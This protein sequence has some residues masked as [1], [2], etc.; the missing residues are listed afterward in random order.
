VDNLAAGGLNVT[1]P[2][3]QQA[4]RAGALQRVNNTMVGFRV[5]DVVGNAKQE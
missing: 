2:P 1:M 3:V 4:L 5:D